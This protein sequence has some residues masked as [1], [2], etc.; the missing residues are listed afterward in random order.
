M[1]RKCSFRARRSRARRGTF[2]V[3]RDCRG[4]PRP[5]R[6]VDGRTLRPRPQVAH[7]AQR[8]NAPSHEAVGRS[9]GSSADNRCARTVVR[10]PI[11]NET[12]RL[13]CVH[14]RAANLWLVP[15]RLQQETGTLREHGPPSRGEERQS[16]V[17]LASG[18]GRPV[19]DALCHLRAIRAEPIDS[20]YSP[21]VISTIGRPGLVLT[22]CMLNE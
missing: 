14:E 6:V 11:A 18:S 2:G 5:A 22:A 17:P 15:T 8:P 4:Q 19:S 13:S 21:T 3:P 16:E 10:L 20:R 12:Q 1:R 7:S 9:S